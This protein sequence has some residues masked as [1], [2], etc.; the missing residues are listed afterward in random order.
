[1]ASSAFL[2]GMF[3]VLVIG[4]LTGHQLAFVLGGIGTVFGYIG[5]GDTI[6]TIFATRIWDTMNSYS[7]IAIPMFVLMA[8]FLTASGVAD[9]LFDSVKLLFGKV[10]GGLGIAVIVVS[11]I[12]AATTGVVGASVTTMGLLALPVLMKNGYN[13]E[14][15]CGTVAAGG[16]LGILIPPSMMLVLMGSYSTVSV[17]TLFSA[18][19]VPGLS[20]SALYIIYIVV[21]CHIHPEYGPGMS[22]EELSQYT[23]ATK[24]KN[25]AVN[26]VPPLILILAV[27]GSIFTGYAT[28]TEASGVGAFAAMILCACYGKLNWKIIHD[29]MLDTAKTTAMCFV[30]VFGANAF[31]SAFLGMG[32]ADMVTRLVHSLG[33]SGTG[34]FIVMLI[35]AFILGCFIDWIGIVMILFPIFLPILDSYGYDRMVVVATCA[36]L[37]QTCFLT[38]PFGFSL[39]YLNGLNVPGIKLSHIYRGIIPFVVII[40]IVTAL[41]IAFPN[42]MYGLAM[43]TAEAA[44]EAAADAAVVAG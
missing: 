43:N 10:K 27:L 42:V 35:I 19:L 11:T 14:L 41:C 13:K 3:V 44:A 12:F 24:L 21:M 29:S 30:I 15:S 40:L 31:S 38:P 5:W 20:L 26:L 34:V 37:L 28:P 8:N 7:L 17:G 6:N 23:M 39:F 32:G 9:G 1:M 4:L 18:A 16:T 25:C 36:V 2:I 33:L 22:E